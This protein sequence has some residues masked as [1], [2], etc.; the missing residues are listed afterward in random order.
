MELAI[1]SRAPTARPRTPRLPDPV[2][3]SYDPRHGPAPGPRV[4]EQDIGHAKEVAMTLLAYAGQPAPPQL[5]GVYLGAWLDGSRTLPFRNA[6]CGPEVRDSGRQSRYIR[7]RP[8][9]VGRCVAGGGTACLSDTDCPAGA[10]CDGTPGTCAQPGPAP[11][12]ADADCPATR[13]RAFAERK[14]CRYGASGD[15]PITACTSDADC[16]TA[17]CHGDPT[18]CVCDYR[19]AELYVDTFDRSSL[20]DLLADPDE[21]PLAR[22]GSPAS[23]PLAPRLRC[24]LD[25]WWAPAGASACPGG[26]DPAVA[27]PP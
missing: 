26:C 2:I 8:G 10:L 24:C 1:G 21:R 4:G 5:T 18:G 23:G 25:A 22:G 13:H 15:S 16:R 12:V 17:A 3:H 27:G 7:T 11:C 19:A 14:R 9:V 6:L 20:T